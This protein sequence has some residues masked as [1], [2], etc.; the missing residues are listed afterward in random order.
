MSL[1]FLLCL[2]NRTK[3]GLTLLRFCLLKKVR[4]DKGENCY[5]KQRQTTQKNGSEFTAPQ[6]YALSYASQFKCVNAKLIVSEIRK[7]ENKHVAVQ[8][9]FKLYAS[10]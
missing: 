2:K 9:L 3:A 10:G 5:T 1:L 6:I 4:D 7:V 8:K